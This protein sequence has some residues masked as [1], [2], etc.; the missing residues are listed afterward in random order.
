[1]RFAVM[2]WFDTLLSDHIT[3]TA[4]AVLQYICKSL[5]NFLIIVTAL[6]G[7]FVCLIENF[8]CGLAAGMF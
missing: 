3:T 4:H 6:P 7:Y 5:L 2:H 1:M 8:D